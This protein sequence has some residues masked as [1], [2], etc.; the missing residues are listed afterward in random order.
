[1]IKIYK[2]ISILIS[3]V[4]LIFLLIRL[5]ISKE[6]IQSIVEKFSFYKIKRPVGEIIWI[7]GVSIGEAKTA[8]TIAEEIRGKKPRVNILIS[9]STITSYNLISK[10]KKGFILIYSPLDINFVVN[11]FIKFWN[12]SLAI[13]IESEIWPNI[14]SCLKNNSIKLKIFNARISEKSY[15]NWKKINVFSKQIFTLID[16]CFAQ[17]KDS[18]ERF[19]KLGV[20]NVKKIEN[21]KFLSKQLEFNKQNY[22]NLKKKLHNKRIVTL[23][24]SHRGEEELFL[25]C[26]NHL[27]KKI[28]NLFFIIIPR[29]T[30]RKD[31]IIE[32]FNRKKML[33]NI[34]DSKKSKIKNNGPL[35]VCTFGELGLFFKLSEVAIVGGSFS[36]NGGHNPIETNGFNCSVIFGPNM[37]NFIDI[38]NAIVDSNA[39]FE[40]KNLDGLNKKLFTILKNKE[41]NVKVQRNFQKLCNSLSKTSKTQLN[42][43]L[44]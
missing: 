5:L 31:K 18:L 13:F 40:V 24:S 20:K 27:S 33:Y 35:I 25:N 2:S 1:M 12:P 21:L 28:G 9:T 37:G 44:K 41:L 26:Y 22:I 14:F 23:F 29:H 36:E 42:Y 38:R 32:V 16:S 6:K 34:R 43:L 30:E 7:N 15:L 39:G 19:K 17:D 8:I 4:I 3:P 10:N 11:R